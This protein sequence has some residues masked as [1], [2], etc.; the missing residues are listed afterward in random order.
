MPIKF[1]PETCATIIK[2]TAVKPTD[3]AA[4]SKLATAL[5]KATDTMLRW[6]EHAPVSNT[7]ALRDW[8]AP[9][10]LVLLQC[11]FLARRAERCRGRFTSLKRSYRSFVRLRF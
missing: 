9:L 7:L 6:F 3:A 10:E 2:F 8:S 11:S 4:T 5:N 1:S